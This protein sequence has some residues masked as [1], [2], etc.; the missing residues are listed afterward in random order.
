MLSS[1]VIK[2]QNKQILIIFKNNSNIKIRHSNFA[3][4][5]FMDVIYELHVCMATYCIAFV[6]M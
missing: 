3:R 1:F 5:I 2:C 6:C 4:W